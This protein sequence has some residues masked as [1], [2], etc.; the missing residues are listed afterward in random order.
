VVSVTA[1]GGVAEPPLVATVDMLVV[2]A[3]VAAY[4]VVA[5]VLVGFATRRSFAEARGPARGAR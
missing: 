4:A 5:A 1:R 2:G 3:G